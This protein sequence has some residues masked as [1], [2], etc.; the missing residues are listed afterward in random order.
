MSGP[1]NGGLWYVVVT[2]DD[3]Y[4]V[5]FVRGVPDWSGVLG[6]A[7]RYCAKAASDALRKVRDTGY[8]AAAIGVTVSRARP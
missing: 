6:M 2:P 8:E 4:L 7:R 1:I 3:R 5:G